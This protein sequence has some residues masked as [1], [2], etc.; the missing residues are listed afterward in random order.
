MV[1][2]MIIITILVFLGVIGVSIV[3]QAWGSLIAAS[4][5]LLLFLCMLCCF[6]K[7]I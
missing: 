7:E 6:R 3:S 2:S 5:G 1:Y 4:I